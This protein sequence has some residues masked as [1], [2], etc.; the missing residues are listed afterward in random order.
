MITTKTMPGAG[1]QV[2][3]C[4]GT[5]AVLRALLLLMNPMMIPKTIRH[6]GT[7]GRTVRAVVMIATNLVVMN[8]KI[9]GNALTLGTK[10][11]VVE[12]QDTF[13]IPV[14]DGLTEI[15]DSRSQML[16]GLHGDWPTNPMIKDPKAKA[17]SVRFHRRHL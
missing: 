11:G 17:R 6:G 13:G 5:T 8:F 9:R 14:K 16:H 3:A 4:N 7:S 2:N 1:G 12:E 10:A 15:K